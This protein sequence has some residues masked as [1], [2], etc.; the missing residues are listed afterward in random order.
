MGNPIQRP[1]STFSIVGYDPQ[2]G[3]IG[4]AVQSKFLAAGSVVPWARAGLGAI[5]VQSWSNTD[6]VEPAF[7]MI[8]EGVHPEEIM[9]ALTA[10][11]ELRALRQVGIV[12]CSGRSATFSGNEC[13]DW[14]GGI[15]GP[16]FAAQGNILVS[17]AT[18]EALAETF[19]SSEGDL[20]ERLTLALA[21]GQ[22]A[23]GDRRGMQSA[24]L[25]I[26]KAGG[27]YGGYGDRY[28]D[29]R[30]DD[31]QEPINE[32]RRILRLWRLQFFKTKPGNVA[33]IE[34]DVKRFILRILEKEGYYA[35]PHGDW[36]S[37]MQN[38]FFAFSQMENFEEREAEDG[39]IDREVLEYLE[40]VYEDIS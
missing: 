13:M 37:N 9:G 39:Y 14:A 33:P 15:C 34:G 28:V 12:D 2:T 25:Y 31:H 20:S 6:Y 4:I 38:A 24:A 27:G 16:N 7:K 26:A 21:N 8:A 36:N 17:R 22:K 23:G 1:V 11:D 19:K 18:V 32:L 40:G 3:E 29:I 10:N 30:V 5:A 35:G